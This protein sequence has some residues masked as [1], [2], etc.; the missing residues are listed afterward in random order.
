[1]V[2]YGN[3]P[4]CPLETVEVPNIEGAN[5]EPSL[6][7]LRDSIIYGRGYVV[8]NVIFGPESDIAQCSFEYCAD[9]RVMGTNI[10]PLFWGDIFE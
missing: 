7:Y 5:K 3:A 2:V 4:L 8:A 10:K 9:C 6:T 1:M